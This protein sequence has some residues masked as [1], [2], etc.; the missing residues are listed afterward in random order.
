MHNVLSIS[1]PCTHEEEPTESNVL[2]KKL[3][4]QSTVEEPEIQERRAQGIVDNLLREQE[5]LRSLEISNAE[6]TIQEEIEEQDQKKEE[7]D[8]SRPEQPEPPKEEAAAVKEPEPE[9]E[10]APVATEEAK[11]EEVVGEEDEKPQKMEWDVSKKD[12]EDPNQE[13]LF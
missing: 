9:K 6:E 13:K 1:V 3:I 7:E 10:E 11:T 12:E 2:I 5:E 8:A 4:T